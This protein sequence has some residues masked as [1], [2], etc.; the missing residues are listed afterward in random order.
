[1]GN[2]G[3]TRKSISPGMQHLVSPT[4][5]ADILETRSLSLCL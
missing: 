3:L 2:D 5:T 1:M 4:S